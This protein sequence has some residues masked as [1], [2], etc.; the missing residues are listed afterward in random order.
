MVMN[1]VSTEVQ[2]LTTVTCTEMQVRGVRWNLNCLRTSLNLVN[3][4]LNPLPYNV[5]NTAL[6]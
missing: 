3:C 5:V 1:M 2:T 6:D 4:V